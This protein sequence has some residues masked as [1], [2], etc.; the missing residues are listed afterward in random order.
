MDIK[1]YLLDCYIANYGET[2]S[3]DL[4]RG[5]VEA[6]AITDG[7]DRQTGEKWTL[8]ESKSIG[9]KIG[10]NWDKV[11]PAEFYAVLNMMYSDYCQVGRK[12]GLTDWQLYAELAAAWFNDIDAAEN[13]T[14]NYFFN[15]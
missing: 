2:I 3:D 12:H 7:S 13:K 8:E 4:A 9:E 11:S 10:I 1:K 6:M 15:S 14:F 5:I